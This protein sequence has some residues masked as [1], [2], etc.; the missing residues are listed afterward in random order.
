VIVIPIEVKDPKLRK[1]LF[2]SENRKEK[3]KAQT[4]NS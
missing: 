2:I 1:T 3:K 4:G